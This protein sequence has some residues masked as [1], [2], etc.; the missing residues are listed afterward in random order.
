MLLKAFVM[1]VKLVLAVGS[2]FV[3]LVLGS[4]IWD[5]GF[6]EH[7]PTGCLRPMLAILAIGAMTIALLT[8]LFWFLMLEAW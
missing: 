6:P 5:Y 2:F 8:G 4:L 7:D 3:V 1:A